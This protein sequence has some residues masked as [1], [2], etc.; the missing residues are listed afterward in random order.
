M[1]MLDNVGGRRRPG[2][3][4]A[5]QAAPRSSSRS[6]RRVWLVVVIA[7]NMCSQSYDGRRTERGAR[8][9]HKDPVARAK[10]P[11]RAKRSFAILQAILHA[12]NGTAR[13]GPVAGG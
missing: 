9:T 1:R 10:R 13:A 3:G 12:A 7:G 5:G 4:R 8:A 11:P 2:G 6:E